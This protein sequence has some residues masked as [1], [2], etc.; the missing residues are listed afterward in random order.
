[1][2]TTTASTAP[3]QRAL[4]V[5]LIFAAL[6]ALLAGTVAVNLQPG[7]DDSAQYRQAA[8]NIVQLGDPYATTAPGD[9][10]IPP[11]PNPPLLAYLL[12][13][14]LPLGEDGGRG[15]WFALNLAAWAAFLWLC[16]RVAAPAWARRHWGPLAAALALSPPTY[17]C[18]LYG[19]LGIMLALLL[20]A[21]FAL[22]G[23]RPAA[24]G[25]ALALAAA[26]K[27]YPGLVGFHFL[28][29]GP[30]HVLGW[31]AGAGLAMLAAPTLF[32]GLAPYR[33]YV[34][35]V[36]LSGFY[37]YAAE[38]N[39]SLMGLFR[40]LFTA[41]GHFDALADAPPLALGLTLVVSLLVLGVCLWAA[42]TPGDDGALLAF[43]LWFTAS[44]L[45]SPI[46]GYY[47]LAALAFPGLVIA[48]ELE[49]TPSRGLSAA[50]V[51]ATVLICL[52]PGWYESWPGLRPALERGWGLALLVPPIYGLCGYVAILAALAAR[53]RP[54]ISGI[55]P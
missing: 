39:V 15:L 6:A 24:S 14:A 28:L 23:R 49:R 34:T 8:R 42:R 12:V 31:A 25:A 40:R 22:A 7:F 46:N 30:R 16:L 37:P 27:L 9:W 11:Y 54:T 35:K 17:L 48:R 38:F 55:L 13:P 2:D 45:L 1:M 18:L 43:A 44:L 5:N 26:L 19:Q 4:L 21:S 3:R 29:R 36:L 53:R 50:A 10:T 51:L 41:A 52:P 20:V 33:T 47:N 32:H